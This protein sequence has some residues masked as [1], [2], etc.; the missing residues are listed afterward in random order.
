MTDDG[1][2][3]D[4]PATEQ[5]P[6]LGTVGRLVDQRIRKWQ[7]DLLS[8]KPSRQAA[9][10]ATLARLRRG[11][12]KEPGTVADI[13]QF[14]LAPVLAGRD[15]PEE[16][17]PEETAVHIA[18]TLYA[19]H[20]QSRTRPMHRR[21]DSIGRALCRLLGRTEP[22]IPPDPVTRRFQILVTADDLDELTHHARGVV[23]L[24]RSAQPTAISLDYGRLAEEL[25][26]WQRPGGAAQVRR[27]WARDFYRPHHQ[28]TATAAASGSTDDLIDPE[29]N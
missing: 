16:S 27:K 7:S 15:A 5:R 3:A 1:P 17:T 2:T 20:Q 11:A 26:Q 9:G 14:T 28:A 29:G 13:L 18:V 19:L 10:L 6:D 12:G 21:G 4:A 8:D 23:Q 24:L 22:A 25:V